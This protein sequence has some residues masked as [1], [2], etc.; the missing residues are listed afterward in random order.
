MSSTLQS[1]TQTVEGVINGLA[2]IVAAAL[3]AA[4]PAI[5][6]LDAAENVTNA[7]EANLD[8]HTAASDVAVGLSALAATPAVQ[9][10]PVIAAKLSGM[11][12]LFHDFLE[13]IGIEK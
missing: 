11:A 2:P 8:H 13:L 12:L 7:V 5:A 10:N 3:P 6:G 9:N 4:A 1:T